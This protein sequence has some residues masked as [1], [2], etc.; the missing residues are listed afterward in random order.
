MDAPIWF[1]ENFY[2]RSKLAQLNRSGDSEY[3]TI[4]Q[5]RDAIAAAG[6]TVYDHFQQFSLEEKTSP[7]E[8][9]NTYE[10]L[11][12]KVRQL[13]ADTDE[14]WTIDSVA[15]AF[16]EAGYMTAWDHYDAHGI[17]EGLDPSNAFSSI[18]YLNAKLQQ[19]QSTDADSDWTLP[20]LVA[21]LKANDL[22]PVSHYA[23]S[24]RDEDLPVFPVPDA[25]QVESDPLADVDLSGP[26][27]FDENYYLA[28]KLAQLQAGETESEVQ[29]IE[30]LRVAIETAGFTVYEH[31]QQF[32]LEEGTS[33]SAYF[34][35]PEYLLAKVQQLNDTTLDDTVWDVALLKQAL[36]DAGY[37]NAWDHFSGPGAQEGVN[38]SNAFD[39]S[40]Y[41]DEKLAQLQQA[42]PQAHWNP[43][44]LQQALDNAGLNALTHYLEH[45]QNEGL[46]APVVPEDERVENDPLRA[47]LFTVTQ[48]GTEVSFA[49]GT[50]NI[51]VTLNGTVATFAR[52]EITDPLN[53]VDFAEGGI[54]LN[55][56]EDQA[57]AA[58]IADLQGVG[59]AGEGHLLLSDAATVEQLGGV[60]YSG[61]T[62][63]VSYQLV[64]TAANLS[65]AG[66]GIVAGATSVTANMTDEGDT[67]V[68]ATSAAAG[69]SLTVNGGAGEDTLRATLDAPV[70]FPGQAP[71]VR[72]VETLSLQATVAGA[73]LMMTHITGAQQVVNA[74]STADLTVVDAGNTVAL[75]ATGVNSA[76]NPLDEAAWNSNSNFVLR[77]REGDTAG[78]SQQVT[79]E[80][81][82]LNLLSVTALGRDDA[83]EIVP[84]SAGITELD[85]ISAGSGPNAIRTFQEGEAGLQ[86][87]VETI[88]I[89]GE[90]NLTIIDLPGS[91]TVVNASDATGDLYLV[92]NGEN[93]IAM[94][95]G[96]GNDTLFG[97]SGHDTIAGGAGNDVLYGR[98]G[99]DTYTGGEGND[100]FVIQTDAVA[101]DA[102]DI[103][104]DFLV[105]DNQ[106]NFKVDA[107]GGTAF[108]KAAG[109]VDD[110]AAALA[111]ATT[112]L[113]GATGDVRVNAQQAGADLWVFGDT[114]GNGEA[115]AV[116][117]LVGVGLDDFQAGHVY[118]A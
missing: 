83:G 13:N 20:K 43:A 11:E 1:N 15:S 6:L 114:D 44:K 50:G 74:G 109:A 53:T 59:I 47:D 49:N 106:L 71:T 39:L 105:G 80:Q 112:A 60:D 118:S 8:H 91:A 75:T 104:Q 70:S 2:L 65:G 90:Q 40:L 5:V 36:T 37:T 79:L 14:T 97:G 35:T 102:A 22:N 82:S 76:Q 57:L 17:D 73:G 108:S 34:N 68:A 89:T 30:Q 113:A 86:A 58:S 69:Q 72:Q 111:A 62:G 24:G 10:Y 78:S 88:T 18:A 48:E 29:D 67:Y 98:A 116:V 103:V 93:D 84:A 27:W 64:D 55:L 42:E 23:A 96:S 85:L 66:P 32:S 28:S 41:L 107:T 19:L 56:S 81:S 54:R 21:A 12:A 52:G 115:D 45:G 4:A 9:F 61:V 100:T 87:S 117:Q 63:T 101:Q 26:E 33:P 25:Q 51:S 46:A 110:F 3:T 31:F 95:G 77:Y 92:Y 16:Q 94:T 7:S 38:P 99:A